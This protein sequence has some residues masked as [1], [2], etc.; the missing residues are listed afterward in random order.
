[1]VLAFV[2]LQCNEGMHD[3]TSWSEYFTPALGAFYE[4]KKIITSGV[5]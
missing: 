3:K 4:E 5:V 1:M 2:T